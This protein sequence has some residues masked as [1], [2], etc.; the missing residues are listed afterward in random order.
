M[1]K[2]ES[3]LAACVT[4]GLIIGMSSVALAQKTSPPSSFTKGFRDTTDLRP[5]RVSNEGK[6]ANVDSP[7]L[8]AKAKSLRVDADN[9]IVPEIKTQ[10]KQALTFAMP[11]ARAGATVENVE[12]GTRGVELAWTGAVSKISGRG[13]V[14]SNTPEAMARTAGSSSQ[15]ESSIN[16]EVFSLPRIIN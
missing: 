10:T 1:K 11:A 4:G 6:I 14:S 16:P 2:H 15:R 12:S 5:S 13:E 7:E 3:V 9:S 8:A